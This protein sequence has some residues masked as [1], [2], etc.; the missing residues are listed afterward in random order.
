QVYGEGMSN[1]LDGIRSIEEFELEGM[2]VFLRLDLNVPMENGMIQDD[3][4]LTA[5]LPTIKYAIEKGAKLIIASHLGRPKGK[6]NAE[7]SLEPIAEEL[8]R[9]LN[10]EVNFI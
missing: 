3:T 5:A 8:N 9:R 1:G 7:L 2:R 4:R 6:A 10:Q